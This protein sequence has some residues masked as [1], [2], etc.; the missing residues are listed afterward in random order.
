M[1]LCEHEADLCVVDDEGEAVSGIV[2]DR[3]EGRPGASFEDSENADGDVGV[4]FDGETDDVVALN[5]FLAQ[6]VCKAVVPL[7]LSWR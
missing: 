4:A 2:L 5:A 7:A 3:G 6:G 1:L